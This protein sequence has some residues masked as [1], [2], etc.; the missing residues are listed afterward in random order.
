MRRT[1]EQ[2]DSKIAQ[3]NQQ[4]VEDSKKLTDIGT[5]INRVKSDRRLYATKLR[6]LKLEVKAATFQCADMRRVLEGLE[7]RAA[8]EEGFI[9]VIEIA[10]FA[11]SKRYSL[12]PRS[13]AGAIAG[14]P[15]VG[16]LHSAAKCAGFRSAADKHLN[17]QIFQFVQ[18]TCELFATKNTRKREANLRSAIVDLPQMR[19]LG[20]QRVQNYLRI[21]LMENW[22]YL[23]AVLESPLSALPAEVP[24][25]ITSRFLTLKRNSTLE[26]DRAV[27]EE[28][29]ITE[30]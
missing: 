29:R 6:I 26:V 25:V 8:A 27:A 3:F 9:Y 24:F 23:S 30:D 2:T 15:Y 17:Y 12:N 11:Q 28:H 19:K 5:R 16:A 21:F 14:L 10:K 22:Y 7:L 20:S 4:I 13:I 18:R 1:E